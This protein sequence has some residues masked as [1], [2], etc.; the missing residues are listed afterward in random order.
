M[1]GGGYGN[2]LGGVE[3]RDMKYRGEGGGKRRQNP[4]GEGYIVIDD[5]NPDEGRGGGR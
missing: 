3:S 1:G 5:K 4:K 2:N